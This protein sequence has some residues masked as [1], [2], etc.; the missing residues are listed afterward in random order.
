[1]AAKGGRSRLQAVRTMKAVATTRALEAPGG[2]VEFETTTSI[3]YPAA[4]RVD[5]ALPAGPVVQVF[6]A[7]KAWV[8][9]REHGVRQA[10]LAF[11]EELRGSVQR[12]SI[13]LLLG[14]A[15]GRVSARRVPGQAAASESAIEVHAPG[16]RP[17]TLV[18]DAA[19]SLIAAVRYASAAPKAVITEETF[20]DYRDVD[21]I[22]VAFKATVSR[23]GVAVIDRVLR[24]IEFNVPLEPALFTRPS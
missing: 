16:M 11:A 13:P 21:G 10:P 2:P 23:N 1:V 7:G 9:D 17:V 15:D 22:M 8:Q 18:F 19:T 6:N 24:R 12:D 20:S 5:A 14:L 4:F 3:Q